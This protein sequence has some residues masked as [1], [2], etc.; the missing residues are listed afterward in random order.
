[1][2]KSLSDLIS[3]VNDLAEEQGLLFTYDIT[4]APKPKSPVPDSWEG[5]GKVEGYCLDY[6]CDI[7]IKHTYSLNRPTKN[8]FPTKELAQA[9]L[10]IAQ[11]SQ[12]M[13]R[14]WDNDGGWRPKEYKGKAVI[15]VCQIIFADSMGY[16]R[17]LLFRNK[18][19]ADDFITKHRELIDQAAPILFGRVTE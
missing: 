16:S 6:H 9:S 17:F 4:E 3:Q 14:T 1:M 8:V 19:I 5:L 7:V 13:Y 11:L 15:S 10:A 2:N 12:L 18:E